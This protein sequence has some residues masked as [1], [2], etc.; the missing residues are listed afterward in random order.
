[1]VEAEA[2]TT[3]DVVAVEVKEVVS[4]LLFVEVV[5]V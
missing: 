1:V 5:V 2:A 4:R 3:P